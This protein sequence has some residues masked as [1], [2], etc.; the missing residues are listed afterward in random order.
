[1]YE[2][3]PC[4]IHLMPCK[5]EQLP[6]ERCLMLFVSRRDALWISLDAFLLTKDALRF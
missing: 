6:N 3:M 4:E 1:V 2:K 5:L